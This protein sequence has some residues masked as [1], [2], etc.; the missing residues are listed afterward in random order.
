ML[1]TLAGLFPQAWPL[2]CVAPLPPPCSR[3][4]MQHPSVRRRRHLGVMK[5]FP[6]TF[7]LSEATIASYPLPTTPPWRQKSIIL[8]EEMKDWGRQAGL[9]SGEVDQ[10]ASASL[11]TQNQ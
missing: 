4:R 10:L 3:L 2:L 7:G 5:Y 9:P 6:T 8:P 11:E 1:M